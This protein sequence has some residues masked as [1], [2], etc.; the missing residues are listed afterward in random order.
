MRINT[1]PW[2]KLISFTLVCVFFLPANILATAEPVSFSEKSLE[3]PIL[4]ES[5]EV[6]LRLPSQFQVGLDYLVFEPIS[7]KMTL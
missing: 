1:N 6:D 7:R 3:N 5:S 4:V 2:G